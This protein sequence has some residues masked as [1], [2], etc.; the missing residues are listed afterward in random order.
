MASP[1]TLMLFNASHCSA[2]ANLGRWCSYSNTILL[3]FAM[4]LPTIASSKDVSMFYM[5]RGMHTKMKQ[6]TTTEMKP[7]MVAGTMMLINTFT[8]MIV[9]KL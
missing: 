4:F 9:T 6:Q 1:P 5:H 3:G 8:A 7:T 2:Y